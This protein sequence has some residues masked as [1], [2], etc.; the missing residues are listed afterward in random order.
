MKKSRKSSKNKLSKKIGLPP[1]SLVYVGNMDAEMASTKPTI[2]LTVY[3]GMDVN[4]NELTADTLANFN[5]AEYSK[6]GKKVWLNVHGVHDADL[7]KQIGDLFHLHP[8]VQE[9]ILNTQQRPKIDEYDDYVFLEVQ[10]FKYDKSNNSMDSE[11]ISFVLGHDYLLT[12]QERSTGIFEPVRTRLRASR[13]N[14]REQGVDYLAYALL[15]SVVDRYFSVLED[16]GDASEELEA[17]LLSRPSNTELQNIHQ[18]KQ[19]S[20]ELRRAVW[21]LREVMN[22][23]IRNES[24]FFKESTMPYLRDVYD[25]TVNFIESLESIRDS[26]SSMMDIYMASMSNRVNLEL[27]ALTVVTMLFMP[28]TLISGIFGMNFER[29]PWLKDADGFW[30]A[31]GLMATIASI[32]ILIFW[33]RQWLSSKT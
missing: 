31:I 4:E 19:V 13:A 22:N 29:M 23:L 2:T 8:L 17:V 20:V 21:P 3:N 24:E 9:D 7:I 25:H 6:A 15:D 18:L 33:R 26:L 5:L 32:M 11:Q 1:G 12:F 14:I 27:R 16:V 10:S 30:W 28:A